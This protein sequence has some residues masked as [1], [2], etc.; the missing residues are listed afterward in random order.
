METTA[1]QAWIV[2]QGLQIEVA[3]MDMLQA[4]NLKEVFDE[5][6]ENLWYTGS[7]C[8]NPQYVVEHTLPELAYGYTAYQ[9]LLEVIRCLQRPVEAVGVPAMDVDGLLRDYAL[10]AGAGL[11]S[12]AGAWDLLPMSYLGELMEHG[13][14][15]VTSSVAEEFLNKFY[16][17]PWPAD[18]LA[19]YHQIVWSDREQA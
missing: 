10:Y 8:T 19:K 15:Q 13:D 12:A 9:Q 11:V 2:N 16:A 14:Y 17:D 6:L 7:T 5:Y 3:K 18:V 1:L 4:H